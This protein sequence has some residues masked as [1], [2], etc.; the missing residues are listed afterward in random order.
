MTSLSY[1]VIPGSLGKSPKEQLFKGNAQ[2]SNE[3]EWLT[4]ITPLPSLLTLEMQAA[5]MTLAYL[6]DAIGISPHKPF[7]ILHRNDIKGLV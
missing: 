3:L 6:K 4:S 2:S 5:I 1:L 7:F